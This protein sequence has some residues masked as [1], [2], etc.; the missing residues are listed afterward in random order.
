VSA[1]YVATAAE[2]GLPIVIDAP[3]WWARPDR[4]AARGIT[5]A[6]ADRMLRRSAEVLL[7]VRDKYDDVYVSAS[8]GPSTDGYRAGEVDL[9][10]AISY[11]RWEVE[12]LAAT[13]VDFL[14]AATFSTTVDLE[15]IAHVFDA[16]GRPYVLGPVVDASGCLPDGIPLREAIDTIESRVETPPLFWALCCTHPDIA[17]RAMDALGA[18]DTHAHGRVQQLKGNGSAASEEE[19]DAADH[20]L[21]DEPEPWAAAAMRLR[22]DH[23]LAIVGGCCGTDDRHLLSLAIRLATSDPL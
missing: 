4:L 19:R 16:T 9:E 14:L 5:G 23:G 10:T 12:G 6:D 21:C 11:H 7:P 17:G 20:V 13:D 15:A 8:L 18:A 3:S 22:D 1:G 2:L